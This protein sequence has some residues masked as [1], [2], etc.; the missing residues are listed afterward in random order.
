MAH[1]DCLEIEPKQSATSSVIWLHGLGASANDFVPVIPRLNLP[2]DHAIRFIFPQAPTQ[3][4]SL[5]QGYH[6]PAW[7]DIYGLALDSQQDEKG[8][9]KSEADLAALIAREHERGIA[10]DKI[11][12][13]GF[14]QGG[15]MALHTALRFPHKL[16]GVMVLSS[17]LP[18]ADFMADEK[19]SA[20][21]T[22]SIFVAHGSY[23]HVLPLVAG[24]MTCE[25]LRTHNYDVAW[26]VY[27]M[28]HEVC[29]EEIADISAWLQRVLQ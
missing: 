4:V 20:N 5:N 8:I 14:S 6:M 17:Y 18:L 15:A 23:D 1:L 10:L 28:A 7:Y 13:A 12:L 29:A 22:T 3:P 19:H 24:E 25:Y 2:E 9:R 16:A 27:D 21:A 26:H 11:I